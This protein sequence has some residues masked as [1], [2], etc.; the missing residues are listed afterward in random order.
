MLNVQKETGVFL[1][2][3]KPTK[4]KRS[5]LLFIW[6]LIKASTYD[7]RIQIECRMKGNAYGKTFHFP[8][9]MSWDPDN[10]LYATFKKEC[11][12]EFPPIAHNP[13]PEALTLM[14]EMNKSLPIFLK[15]KVCCICYFYLINNSIQ[16]NQWGFKGCFRYIRDSVDTNSIFPSFLSLIISLIWFRCCE[17][18]FRKR[19]RSIHSSEAR[20]PTLQLYWNMCLYSSCKKKKRKYKK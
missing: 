9:G 1:V 5:S 14:K 8:N 10:V 7:S 13:T 4:K 11:N 16:I 3:K 20:H 17:R 18:S 15:K 6:I 2:S 12:P 19:W